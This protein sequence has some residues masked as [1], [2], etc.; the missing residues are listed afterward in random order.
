M[1]DFT[2]QIKNLEF[3]L[4]EISMKYDTCLSKAISRYVDSDKDFAN[5]VKPC[6]EIRNNLNDLMKKYNTLSANKL[7]H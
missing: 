2:F 3:H 6:E 1:D 7:D 4:K 5:L